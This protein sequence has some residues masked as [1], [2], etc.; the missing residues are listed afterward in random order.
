[1]P[2]IAEGLSETE[3]FSLVGAFTAWA[4]KQ[5]GK[6]PPAVSTVI[7]NLA[8]SKETSLY[9]GLDRMVQYGD[10]VAKATMYEWLTTQDKAAKTE[11]LELMKNDK[12]LKWADAI[13]TVAL[14]EVNDEFVNYARLPGRWRTYGEDMGLLW[15][16]NYKIRIMK[17]A[18]RRIRKNPAAFL[19]GAELGSALGVAT[20]WDTLPQNINFAD[21]T[22]LDPLFSAHETILWNQM[23]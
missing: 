14:M 23:F 4:E 12:T 20:L 3:E 16:Y 22:G 19:I 15:F 13:H 8:V 17:M 6:M 7:N 21:S 1:M 10:F 11:A 18:F 5:M 2:T 9:M